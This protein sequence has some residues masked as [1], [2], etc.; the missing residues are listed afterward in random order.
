MSS[1]VGGHKGPLSFFKKNLLGTMMGHG[2]HWANV[3]LLVKF[4]QKEKIKTKN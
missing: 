3:I 2:G 1:D 4:F